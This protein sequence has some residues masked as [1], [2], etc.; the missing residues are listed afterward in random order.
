MPSKRPTHRIAVGPPTTDE[1]AT[2]PY[3]YQLAGVESDERDGELEGFTAAI[4][5]GYLGAAV[6]HGRAN[7]NIMMELDPAKWYCSRLSIRMLRLDGEPIAV[8][9]MGS[10]HRLWQMMDR[11]IADAG[12]R[13][14]DTSAATRNFFITALSMSKLHLLAVRPD[15]QARGHARRLLKIARQIG[16]ADGLNMLYGMF[17]SDTRPHLRQFY[18]SHDFTVLAPGQPLS[19]MLATGSFDHKM[20]PRASESYFYTLIE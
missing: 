17:D 2:L 15:Q 3:W 11:L 4:E 12:S 16:K 10:H 13:G 8:L 7:F 19:L 20:F 14:E 6:G 5:G 1:I 9:I 18:S